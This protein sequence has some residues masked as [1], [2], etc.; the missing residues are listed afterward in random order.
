MEQWID[1][2]ATVTAMVNLPIEYS[3]KPV[4]AFGGM[5]LIKRLV[6]QGGI[7]EHLGHTG[8]V[9]RRVEPSL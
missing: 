2:C 1:E 9:F 8:P 6:D 5:A 7:L 3:E 4:T